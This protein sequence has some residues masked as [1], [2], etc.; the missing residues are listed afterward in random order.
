MARRPMLCSPAMADDEADYDLDTGTS[1]YEHAA[2]SPP[3]HAHL[4][5][6]TLGPEYG[7]KS[8][9]SESP[10]SIDRALAEWRESRDG[11]ASGGL[12]DH[13]REPLQ[14][15][16]PKTVNLERYDKSAVLDYV[17]RNS[18]RLGKRLLEVSIL[19]WEHHVSGGQI[20]LKLGL[21]KDRVWELVKQMRSLV[22]PRGRSGSRTTD[23]PELALGSTVP[24]DQDE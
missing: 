13:E 9:I 23:E 1:P 4:P 7:P 22:H 2:Y 17:D 21:K 6:G 20:A 19:Y 18:A 11:V 5:D 16:N 3:W 12:W 8:Y 10:V 14:R 15:A 24:I